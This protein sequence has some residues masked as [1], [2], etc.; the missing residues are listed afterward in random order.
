[1]II[2]LMGVCGTGKTTIGHALS[3]EL[4]WPF[5]DPDSFHPPENI[6]KQR[7]G[8]PLTDEDR[9]PWLNN[10]HRKMAEISAQ[11]ESAI[12]GCSALKERYREILR[13]GISQFVIFHL[14]GDRELVRERVTKR[15]GHFMPASL[16]D[17]QYE[18]LETPKD[19]ISL[20]IALPPQEIVQIILK[21]IRQLRG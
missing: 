13:R 14:C 2:L 1:M 9:L 11:G 3:E 21:E 15:K 20:D 19:A 12:F 5:F 4:S 18:T 7:Q 17:S 8:I 10:I 16:V 6:E